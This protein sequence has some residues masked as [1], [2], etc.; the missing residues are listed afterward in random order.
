[1]R[2]G[3]ALSGF[4]RHDRGAEV[5]L[6]AIAD[7]L[8]RGGDEVTVFGAGQPRAEEAYTFCHVPAIDREHF[9]RWPVFPPFRNE[10]VWEDASFATALLASYRPADFDAVITCAFPFTHLA[11]RRPVRGPRPLQVFVTQNG[12]WPATANRS[13]YRLFACDGLVCTNPDFFESNRARWTSA[14]IPNGIDPARFGGSDVD[15]AQFGLPPG[16]PVVLMVSALIESKRVCDGIR[17]VSR[18][19]GAHLVVAGDGPLRSEVEALAA[20]LLP[21][22]FTRLTLDAGRMPLLYRAADTFLHMSL[23]ESFGNVFVEALASG[24]P[25]VGHDTARL[26]WIVGEGEPLCDTEDSAAL[27]AALSNALSRG[28]GAADTRIERFNWPVIAA[29]YRRFIGS[30]RA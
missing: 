14:L 15:R 27:E 5:A 20:D 16:G 9:E 2:I 18:Q 25:V 26:R 19:P 22:R 8:A 3:F 1:M 7:A 11:L 21:G 12:D 28:R 10:T 30:L 29:E 13:E 17:A 23:L 24:L 6:L 4:H